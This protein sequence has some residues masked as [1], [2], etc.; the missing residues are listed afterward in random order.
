MV[1][2]LNVTESNLI[3][4]QSQVKT[5]IYQLFIKES[6]AIPVEEPPAEKTKEEAPKAIEPVLEV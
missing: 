3:D 2:N 6:Q 1:V 5:D 4:Q